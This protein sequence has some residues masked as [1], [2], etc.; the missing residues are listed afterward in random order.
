MQLCLSRCQ[1]TFLGR[2]RAPLMG[3]GDIVSRVNY[4]FLN[5]SGRFKNGDSVQF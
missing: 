3:S 2:R 1:S 4:T 5:D